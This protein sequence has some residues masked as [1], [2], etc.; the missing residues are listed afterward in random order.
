MAERIHTGGLKSFEV[1]KTE[2]IESERTAKI[3]EAYKK[4]ELRKAKEKR[5]K[6]III[7]GLII[8]LII[9]SYLIFR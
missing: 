8:I 2:K 7:T 5:R 3:E 1:G 9:I 4:A 6:I